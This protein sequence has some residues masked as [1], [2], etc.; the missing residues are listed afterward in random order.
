MSLHKVLLHSYCITLRFLQILSVN[1]GVGE[2]GKCCQTEKSL[3][4]F[5]DELCFGEE[6]YTAVIGT[7]PSLNAVLCSKCST[8]SHM[9]LDACSQPKALTVKSKCDKVTE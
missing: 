1:S 8:E 3:N 7:G 4:Y 2:W 5:I 9:L 6:E